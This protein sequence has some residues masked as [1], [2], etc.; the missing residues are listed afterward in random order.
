MSTVTNRDAISTSL[1]RLLLIDLAVTIAHAGLWVMLNLVTPAVAVVTSVV[2]MVIW[3][4][5]AH[6]SLG[7]VRDWLRGDPDDRRLLAAH[8][9]LEGYARRVALAHLIGWV[10]GDALWLALAFLGIP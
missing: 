2:R 6:H 7:P 10:L 9:T 5:Y 8:V 1:R 4:A 3:L